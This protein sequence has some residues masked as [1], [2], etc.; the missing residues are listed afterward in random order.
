MDMPTKCPFTGGSVSTYR[1]ECGNCTF[2]IPSEKQCRIISIDNNLKRL[3][4][5]I[6]NQQKRY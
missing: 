6:Q 1:N 4:S 3:L 5:I 2:Y